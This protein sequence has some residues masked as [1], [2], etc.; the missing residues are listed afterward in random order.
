MSND[1]R[2]ISFWHF[3]RRPV[4]DARVIVEKPRP[5]LVG[6]FHFVGNEEDQKIFNEVQIKNRNR[7]H[8]NMVE[9]D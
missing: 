2:R 1:I 4:G 3:Q 5:S 7:R 6:A 9:D 8:K